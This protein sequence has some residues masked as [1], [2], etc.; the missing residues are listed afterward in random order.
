LL[1]TFD[2]GHLLR[3]SIASRVIQPYRGV[4]LKKPFRIW[5]NNYQARV[6]F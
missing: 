6:R 4:C 3:T 5:L 2:P 1:P